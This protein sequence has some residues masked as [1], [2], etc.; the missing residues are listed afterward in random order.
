MLSW[1]GWKTKSK[2]IDFHNSGQD[3]SSVPLMSGSADE[4]SACEFDKVSGKKA[5]P[6]IL[7]R[8]D[9]HLPGRILHIQSDSKT[10]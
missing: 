2:T 7:D 6:V 4:E 3:I 9:L 10:K 8:Q 5:L 1:V